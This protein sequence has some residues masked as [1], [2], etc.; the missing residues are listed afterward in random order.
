[1][2]YGYNTLKYLKKNFFKLI[3][4]VILPAIGLA[5]TDNI[6]SF[7]TFFFNF[8]LNTTSVW[9]VYSFFT[10][11]GSRSWSIGIMSVI[12]LV[13]FESLLFG[14]IDRHLKVGRFSFGKSFSTLNET[15][16]IVVPTVL[17][18]VGAYELVAFFNAVIIYFFQIIIPSVAIF[19]GILSTFLLYSGLTILLIQFS[20]VIPAVLVVGYPINDACVFSTRMVSG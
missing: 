11:I 18:L 10:L 6:A 12:V 5:F 7:I 9:T 14:A 19:A 3:P 17:L 1:M 15:V 4:F 16:M 13:F 2:K 8:E 20:E